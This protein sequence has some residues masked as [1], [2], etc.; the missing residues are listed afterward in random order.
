MH[1]HSGRML[2]G[3]KQPGGK[4]PAHK[5][6]MKSVSELSWPSLVRGLVHL[7][8]LTVVASLESAVPALAIV[9]WPVSLSSSPPRAPLPVRA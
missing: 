4:K 3:E 6:G 5:E 7:C 2:L 9:P 1:G 8:S